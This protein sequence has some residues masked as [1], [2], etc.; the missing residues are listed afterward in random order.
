MFA[1]AIADPWS[2]AVKAV[3][4]PTGN[5][6]PSYKVTT[7]KRIPI[8]ANNSGNGF[9]CFGPSLASDAPC[10]S[11]TTGASYVTT[12]FSTTNTTAGVA[13]DFMGKLPFTAAN[14]QANSSGG[15]A[16][17]RIV[18][19]GFRLTYVGPEQ[20]KGGVYTSV[21]FND[22]TS[23]SGMSAADLGDYPQADVR[24]IDRAPED[25]VIYP[26][27]ARE[28]VYSN[29]NGF[30]TDLQVYPFG[31]GV[32]YSATTVPGIAGIYISGAG[33]LAAFELQIIQHTEYIGRGAQPFLTDAISDASGMEMVL[34]AAGKMQA[35]KPGAANTTTLLTL[36]KRALLRRGLS[37]ALMFARDMA[38]NVTRAAEGIYSAVRAGPYR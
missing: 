26:V 6:G 16:S 37:L 5:A 11:Y 9:V 1:V 24:G 15:V 27:G 23:I 21:V 2:Q 33:A 14:L 32:A 29:E 36:I 25:G 12:T 4:I 22:R 38:P 30:D 18:S 20:T 13:V 35:D 8:Y 31:N 28:W 3:G 17:G 34:E 7:T 19:F 10:V